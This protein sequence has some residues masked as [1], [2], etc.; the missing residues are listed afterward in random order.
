MDY[1]SYRRYLGQLIDAKM[2]RQPNF[3]PSALAIATVIASL[4]IFFWT[5]ISAQEKYGAAL[6]L[7]GE[8]KDA[9]PILAQRNSLLSVPGATASPLDV[10]KISMLLT[11]Y[12]SSEWET[13]ITPYITASGTLVRPGIVANNLLPMGTKIKIPEL[14]GDTVFVV[15]DRMNSRKGA[16]QL[17]VWLPSYWEAKQF[18]VK[19]ADIEVLD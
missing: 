5:N 11:A 10:Q 18:G 9:F 8:L 17:D 15:E 4:G 19:N 7:G 12:S 3:G 6:I 16:Y 1:T 14:Y 2:M 13:D